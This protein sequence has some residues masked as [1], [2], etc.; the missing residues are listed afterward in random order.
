VDSKGYG[1]KDETAGAG[2]LRHAAIELLVKRGL[3]PLQI[4]FLL[5]DCCGLLFQFKGAIRVRLLPGVLLF[6]PR[7]V[8]LE[9]HGLLPGGLEFLELPKDLAALVRGERRVGWRLCV[10]CP[11]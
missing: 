11:K 10:C 2:L 7:Y 4:P 3:V 9:N 8:F 5:R 1:A 6:I